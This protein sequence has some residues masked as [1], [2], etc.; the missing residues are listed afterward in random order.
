MAQRGR[1]E[2][3]NIDF[4]LSGAAQVKMTA[5]PS[6]LT[7]EGVAAANVVVAGV[8]NASVYVGTDSANKEYVATIQYDAIVDSAGNGTHTSLSSAVTA[9]AISIYIKSGTYN[10]TTTISFPDNAYIVGENK[11]N[12]IIDFGGNAVG[13]ELNNGV[14]PYETGTISVTNGTATITGTGTLWLANATAGE[15]IR[16]RDTYFLISSVDSNTQITVNT[17]YEGVSEAGLDYSISS[18]R[19]GTFKNFTVQN[20]STVSLLS[21]SNSYRTLIEAIVFHDGGNSGLTVRGSTELVVTNCVSSNNIVDGIDIIDSFIIQISECV[22]INNGDE[23]I[24]IETLNNFGSRSVIVSSCQTNNN[25]GNGISVIGTGTDDII[26]SNSISNNNNSNGINVT[27]T[28][29]KISIYDCFCNNNQQEGMDIDSTYSIIN[30]C[31]VTNN[32][33]EGIDP[34]DDSIVSSCTIEG[35]L[36]G[37]DLTGDNRC[38]VSGCK[39]INNTSDGIL[40]TG[41]SDNNTISCNEINTNGGYGINISSINSTDNVVSSNIINGNTLGGVNSLGTNTNFSGNIINTVKDNAT[42]FAR[43]SSGNV[44]IE[45]L[46]NLR[47][48]LTL[49]G[50][51]YTDGGGLTTTTSG[52]GTGLTVNIDATGGG[53]VQ[54]VTL[55]SPG[56]GYVAGDT[57]TILQ[58]GSSN[59]ATAG[60]VTDT[61]SFDIADQEDTGLSL[62]T[63]TGVVTV[64]ETGKYQVSY[65]VQADTAGTQGAA[66]STLFCELELDGTVVNGSKAGTYAREAGVGVRQYGCGKTISIET[67]SAN[68]TIEVI[69]YKGNQTTMLKTATDSSTIFVKRMG[70]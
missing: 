34:G 37:I 63:T 36:I 30:S 59:T 45:S 2:L 25:V 20:N 62:N 21:I 44:S 69:P 49:G 19:I 35:N 33:N 46:G 16:I 10:E 38:V 42:L 60:L 48:D 8:D 12:T 18:L 4:H 39:I 7:Y 26:I 67:T 22:S 17:N 28:P 14:T 53:I 24:H 65:S 66:R 9:G 13:L 40:L 57:I 70:P 51:A 58:A 15:Y 3:D 61:L 47:L 29:I 43:D 5:T 23:G 52:V 56:T 11:A 55:N 6:T 41:T 68:S 27:G 64:L 32:G 54:T 50:T 1:Y 31:M